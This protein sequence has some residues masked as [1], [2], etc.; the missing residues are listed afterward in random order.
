MV[1]CYSI[2][3]YIIYIVTSLTAYEN[4]PSFS[5][6]FQWPFCVGYIHNF[7]APL[8]HEQ[9]FYS[10]Q[11]LRLRRLRKLTRRNPA[12]AG[13]VVATKPGFAASE[14]M[15][16]CVRNPN[17]STGQ[18]Q[19]YQPS[20]H[21]ERKDPTR[22]HCYISLKSTHVVSVILM[23]MVKCCHPCMVVQEV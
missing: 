15:E 4:V 3:I 16:I 11:L 10:S 7:H 20:H 6:W 12:T 18:Q 8:I 2:Y 5:P 1:I 13:S 19:I 21:L 14:F 23:T 9:L 22:M 17:D